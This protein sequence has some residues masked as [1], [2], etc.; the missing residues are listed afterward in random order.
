MEKSAA[1]R[2]FCNIF[3][4]S[5]RLGMT[6]LIREKKLLNENQQYSPGQSK[7]TKS[8]MY[9]VNRGVKAVCCNAANNVTSGGQ[10]LSLQDWMELKQHLGTPTTKVVLPNGDTF[11]TRCIA[12]GGKHSTKNKLGDK[13]NSGSR[14]DPHP[15]MVSNLEIDFSNQG[16]DFKDFYDNIDS[17]STAGTNKHTSS[18]SE[19]QQNTLEDDCAVCDVD[20]DIIEIVTVKQENN[21]LP[22]K[23]H[24]KTVIYNEKDC[25]VTF[26]NSALVKKMHER[27]MRKSRTKLTRAIKATIDEKACENDESEENEANHCDA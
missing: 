10:T 3:K 12:S 16:K 8:E 6:E 24:K 1:P 7:T 23:T 13:I 25:G 19:K 2:F 4:E 11:D 26:D 17:I 5:F 14:Y 22:A 9:I 21:V 15:G 27:T 18:S 20:S